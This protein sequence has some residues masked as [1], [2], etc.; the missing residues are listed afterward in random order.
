MNKAGD[1]ASQERSPA[2]PENLWK[3]TLAFKMSVRQTLQI[4]SRGNNRSDKK[5]SV[6]ENIPT[7]IDC[8]LLVL[9]VQLYS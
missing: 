5:N 9:P 2:G 3:T 1:K 4:S 8:L 6:P 7:L